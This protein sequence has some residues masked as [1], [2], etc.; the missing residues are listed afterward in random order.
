VC[1]HDLCCDGSDEWASVG[2]VACEDRCKEIGSA[3]RKQDEVR[4]KAR[5]AAIKE[6]RE[7]VAQAKRLRI[8]VEKKIGDLRVLM[9]ADEDKIKRATQELAEVEKA[10]KL[11]VVRAPKKGGKMGML[12]GLTQQRI[13]DLKET[14]LKLAEQKTEAEKR[15]RQLEG[16][17]DKFKEEYNPNFNDEGVKRAVRAWEDYEAT[18]RL[19]VGDYHFEREVEERLADD[20]EHGILWDD[21]ENDDAEVGACKFCSWIDLSLILIEVQCIN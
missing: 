19:A 2:G 14:A 4:Q 11:K 6:R 10:E 8:E 3:W 7:L 15:V 21:Y 9:V 12:V 5:T 18:G 13:K 16:L 17:L 20:S 1:D